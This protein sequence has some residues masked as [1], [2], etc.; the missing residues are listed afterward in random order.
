ML[1]KY[2]FDTDA[3]VKVE[4]DHNQPLNVYAGADSF[5]H[6]GEPDGSSKRGKVS[7]EQLF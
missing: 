2:V 1:T 6:I 7:F 5:L 3:L 4:R